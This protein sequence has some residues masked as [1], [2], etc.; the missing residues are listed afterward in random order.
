MLDRELD[1]ARELEYYVR[2]QQDRRGGCELR[3]A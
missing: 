3:R 1:R 2:P